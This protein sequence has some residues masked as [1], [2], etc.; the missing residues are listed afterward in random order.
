MATLRKKVPA[1]YNQ[2][3]AQGLPTLWSRK[4]V[5][6]LLLSLPLRSR[7]DLIWA[8]HRS[9]QLAALLKFD[10]DDQALIAAVTFAIGVQALE[11]FDEPDLLCQMEAKSLHVFAREAE[12]EATRPRR[13]PRARSGQGNP[14]RFARDLPS[15]L[16]SSTAD[17]RWVLEQLSLFEPVNLFEEVNRQNQEILSLL[18]ALRTSESKLRSVVT[19]AVA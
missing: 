11:L 18:H 2:S 13:I 12:S 6:A 10:P 17:V 19:S 14:M 4:T 8:R 3:V 9:R 16:E 5:M 15:G 1:G 7:R